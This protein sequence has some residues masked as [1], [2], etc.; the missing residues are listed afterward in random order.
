MNRFNHF[1]IP[2]NRLYIGAPVLFSI[3]L[4][5]FAAC[6]K[7]FL[8]VEGKEADLQGKWQKVSAD[9]IFFN[10]QKEIFQHQRYNAE[11]DSFF[12]S[13]GYYKLYGDTAIRLDLL[14]QYSSGHLDYLG[15]DT[16]YAPANKDT[17]TRKFNIE[18]LTNK[19][20]ILSSG[21]EKLTFKKFE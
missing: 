11:Q 18:L 21:E 13:Y 2:S 5:I 14:K 10:F 9:T 4:L 20:L 17:L 8:D 3:I 15:W 6:D 7:L 16:I 1:K 19:K 12:I